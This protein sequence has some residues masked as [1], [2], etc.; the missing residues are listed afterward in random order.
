M[1][2]ELEMATAALV[3]LAEHGIPSDIQELLVLGNPDYGI[4]PGALSKAVRA[5]LLAAHADDGRRGP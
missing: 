2:R 4:A 5:I 3:A 1:P